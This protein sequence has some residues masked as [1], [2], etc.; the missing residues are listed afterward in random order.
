[1][2]DGYDRTSMHLLRGDCE[3]KVNSRLALRRI[4]HS[5]LLDEIQNPAGTKV[6]ARMEHTVGFTISCWAWSEPVIGVLVIWAARPKVINSTLH[7]VGKV[8]VI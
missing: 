4:C 2:A 8:S 6:R 7:P 1:M 3:N 5:G